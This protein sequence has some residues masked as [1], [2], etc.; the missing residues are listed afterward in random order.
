MQP[1][2]SIHLSL[3]AKAPCSGEF[4]VRA[5]FLADSTLNLQIDS[6]VTVLFDENRT[7]FKLRETCFHL[8]KLGFSHFVNLK[9]LTIGLVC[10]LLSEDLFTTERFCIIL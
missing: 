7:D 2:K 5:I 3:I 4:T 1:H 9:T 6:Y 10:C 8:L